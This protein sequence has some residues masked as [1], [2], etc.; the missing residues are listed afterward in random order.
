M[1]R[2]IGI[3]ML[4]AALS[5]CCGGNQ[6]GSQK[7]FKLKCEG[8]EKY[9]VIAVETVNPD[10]LRVTIKGETISM[11]SVV[12]ASGAKYQGKGNAVTNAVLWSKGSDWS[13]EANNGRLAAC[14]PVK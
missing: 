10:L 7:Q 11:P 12:S 1:N 9:G 13:F 3:L 8:Y 14:K 6:S 2:T 4:A 5:G